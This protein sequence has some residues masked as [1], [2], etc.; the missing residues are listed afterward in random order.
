MIWPLAAS[1]VPH[2]WLPNA[3]SHTAHRSRH[4][5]PT[6][7]TPFKALT[8][9][10]AAARLNAPTSPIS[11]S[12]DVGLLSQLFFHTLSMPPCLH[13]ETHPT[14][15]V[16]LMRLCPPYPHRVPMPPSFHAIVD[17]NRWRLL[18]RVAAMG[19]RS[20]PSEP[21][22]PRFQPNKD[23]DDA[24]TSY[25]HPTH[26]YYPKSTDQSTNQ[27]TDQ[28]TGQAVGLMALLA[29]AAKTTL[30]RAASSS[31][32]SSAAGQR[33]GLS[34]VKDVTV[35]VTFVNHEVRGRWC[36]GVVR[37]GGMGVCDWCGWDEMP[38]S[39]GRGSID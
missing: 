18:L 32:A 21:A 36:C 3:K 28:S 39:R 33:R 8:T 7:D 15:L 12:S 14:G 31:G 27:S 29:S 17:Q 13:A 26:I 10:A 1:R 30:R 37:I 24:S 5:Q 11:S 23:G 19:W 2:P 16:P 4:Q 6:H 22:P 38:V 20:N 25:E 9:T 35:N 34:W